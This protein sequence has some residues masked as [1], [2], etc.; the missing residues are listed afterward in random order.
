MVGLWYQLSMTTSCMNC[1]DGN[2]YIYGSNIK[3]FF[4]IEFLE[5]L[6]NVKIWRLSLCLQQSELDRT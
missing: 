2:R 6:L 4:P 3:H 5:P 1:N